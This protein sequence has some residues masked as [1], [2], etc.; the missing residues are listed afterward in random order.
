MPRRFLISALSAILVLSTV[1]SGCSQGSNTGRSTATN[2]AAKTTTA[3]PM[4][5]VVDKISSTIGTQGG[6]VDLKKEG[7]KLVVPAGALSGNS[8]IVVKQLSNPQGFGP[9]TIAYDLT[10]LTALV[11]PITLVFT[12]EKGFTSEELEV[13]GYDTQTQKA[14]TIPYTYDSVTGMSL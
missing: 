2:S 5:V 14:S 13:L 9:T 1:L 3:P 12:T 7:V 4:D 6:E 11:K 10:G 8:S